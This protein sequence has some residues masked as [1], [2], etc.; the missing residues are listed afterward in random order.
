MVFSRKSSLVAQHFEGFAVTDA[1]TRTSTSKSAWII[2]IVV[3][4]LGLAADLVSKEIAFANV[5]ERPVVV[6]RAK[7]LEVMN[8]GSDPDAGSGGT[9]SGGTALPNRA[10]GSGV[11]LQHLIPRHAPVVVIPKVLNFTL[12][13][14][15]GA[16]FGIGAGQ[17]MFFIAFTGI[18]IVFAMFVFTQWT[19]ARDRS[20]HVALGLLISG[21]LG[22]LY[23]RMVFGCVRD[24]I[25]PVPD[26][27]YPW[28]W[29]PLGTHE[30]WPWV[31]NVADLSLIIG[32]GML[33][34]FL[35]RREAKKG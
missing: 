34:V 6:E 31:S 23:D 35:L 20:A 8:G 9:A 17:R 25:H 4:L 12:V 19:T 32:I 3:T 2:L 16:V 7:V 33:A 29:K 10:G 30:V 28:G 18:A 15:P 22:N 5:A 11:T 13:L 14:N 24:F 21:G 1:L 27:V 26:L